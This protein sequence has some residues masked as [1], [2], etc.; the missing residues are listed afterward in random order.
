MVQTNKTSLRYKSVID[1]AANCLNTYNSPC[2]DSDA[3][4]P[5]RTVSSTPLHIL[6]GFEVV[7]SQRQALNSNISL[8]LS[9]RARAAVRFDLASVRINGYDTDNVLALSLSQTETQILP[10]P[11]AV[12]KPVQVKC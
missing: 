2:T 8:I 1:A 7:H 9:T 4:P 5:A 11:Q 6:I 10:R 3:C 12:A